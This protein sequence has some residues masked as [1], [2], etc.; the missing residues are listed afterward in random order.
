MQRIMEWNNG[1]NEVIKEYLIPMKIV[2]YAR[3][4]LAN[5]F[6][7]L[8]LFAVTMAIWSACSGHIDKKLELWNCSEGLHYNLLDFALPFL[9]S[10]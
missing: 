1:S 10:I 9:F 8:C 6:F 4:C 7:S 3:N 2:V 5:H